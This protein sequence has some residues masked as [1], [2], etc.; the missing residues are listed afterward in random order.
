MESVEPMEDITFEMKMNQLTSYLKNIQDKIAEFLNDD[1][2]RDL[3]DDVSNDEVQRYIDYENGEAMKLK[4]NKQDGTS[5]FVLVKQNGRLCDL[6]KSIED[7]QYHIMRQI[8]K[9]I[10]WKYIWKVYCL[11]TSENIIC[12]D[13]SMLLSKYNITDGSVLS[14]VKRPIIRREKKMKIKKNKYNP[15]NTRHIE[16]PTNYQLPPI[17]NIQSNTARK[18]T[19]FNFINRNPYYSN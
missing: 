18:A 3:P 15:M 14:F 4:I 10:S 17:M 12:V 16:T 7:N 9:H 1:L 13:N 2:L 5:Y 6:H 19:D 11:K 8:G